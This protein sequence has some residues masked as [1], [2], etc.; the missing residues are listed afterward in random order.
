MNISARPAAR[1]SSL[2]APSATARLRGGLSALVLAAGFAVL[3]AQAARAQDM[4]WIQVEAQP[5]LTEGNSRA[6]AWGGQFPEAQGYL[7]PSGWHAVALGPF[8]RDEAQARM[9]ELK[10]ERRIPADSYLTD[11]REFRGTFWPAG[12]AMPVAP[13]APT[14]TAPAPQD[15]GTVATT[16]EAPAQPEETLRE[17]R[18]REG[19]LNADERQELQTAL[20]W[21]GFYEGGIDGAFGPGTR[22]SMAAWQTANGHEATGVLTTSQRDRLTGEYQTAMAEYG[23]QQIEEQASGVTITLPMALVD[24]DT[25]AP[26]FVRYKAKEGSDLS[27]MLISQP[28]DDAAFTGLYEV[29]QS[30]EDMPRSGPRSIA[31][32]VFTIEGRDTGR[33]ARAWAR[34]DRGV[35]KGWVMFSDGRQDARDATVQQVLQQ[36]F[37]AIGDTALD[38]GLVPLDE[39]ARRGLVAG[40]ELRKPKSSQSGFY[41]TPDGGVLTASAGLDTCARITLDRDTEAKLTLNDP[42]GGFALLTPER[43]LSPPAVAQFQ[44]EAVPAGVEV[45]ASGYAYGERLPAPVLTFGTFEEAAGLAGEAGVNR[46]QLPALPGDSGAA[47]LAPSGAVIGMVLPAASADGQRQLP[48]GVVF[49]A[50][51]GRIADA[52]IA[53]GHPVTETPAGAPALA[54]EPMVRAA[55]ALTVLVSCWE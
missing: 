15:R 46:V 44:R 14:E 53:A 40:L 39:A 12:A 33:A 6:A 36:S 41:V 25:Y 26:P 48:E 17:A 21:F 27:I 34:L 50:P 7:L 35:I 54:P 43:P 4:M 3:T 45:A 49:T 29:L 47:L 38:P 22:N 37:R 8:T 18:A 19:M 2:A 52:L 51:A 31:T 9:A 1:L 24:F 16:T 55:S 32:S 28:G 23:F 30:L 13:V 5:S 20:Q 11:G 42:E 10:A